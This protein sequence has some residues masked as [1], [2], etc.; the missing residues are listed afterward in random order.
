M[1]ESNRR[2]V[3]LQELQE[4]IGPELEQEF[5]NINNIDAGLRRAL[6]ELRDDGEV[7][8]LG[9]GNYRIHLETN[10]DIA[11]L[12][13][14]ALRGYPEAREQ[15]DFDHESA[16]LIK[17]EIPS[18]LDEILSFDHLTIRGS[19]GYGGLANIPW[20]GIFDE[21]ITSDPKDGLY[22]VYLFDTGHDSIFLTLNQGMTHL[23]DEY[24]RASAREILSTRA[25]LLRSEVDIE[26]FDEGN[27]PLT[28]DLLTAK[29]NLYGTSSIHHREYSLGDLP[30]SAVWIDEVS[31]L[32][33]EYQ[34]VIEEGVYSDV[35]EAFDEDTGEQRDPF[36]GDSALPPPVD[37]YDEVTEAT[38]DVLNRIELVDGEIEKFRD[39]L[40]KSVLK[41]WTEPLKNIAVQ[42]A[43]E[44]TPDEA[45]VIRQ[46]RTVYERNQDWLSERA[47]VLG[48][49]SLY[50]LSPPQ[51]LYMALLRD[52]QSEV[53]D[54]AQV[55]I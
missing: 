38:E 17:D 52:I 16:N 1:T 2:E 29:N 41:E 54:I 32:V 11:E 14:S 4:Y 43:S 34:R 42:T 9:D 36:D 39:E 6:Q 50:A 3:S 46:I 51:V 35:L 55:N 40:S 53:A 26:G 48:I 15:G 22:I 23:Q 30:E 7:E 12:F 20:I 10:P 24:G 13:E 19:V 21:R 28:S 33:E 27:I 8:F 31:R 44:I 47:E 45:V 37:E 18:V 5:P 49:G 25:K